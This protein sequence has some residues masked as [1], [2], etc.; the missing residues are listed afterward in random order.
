MSNEIQKDDVTLPG[1]FRNLII[2]GTGVI[3]EIKAIESRKDGSV[4]LTV[5]YSKEEDPEEADFE[6]IQPKQIEN[7]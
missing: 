1:G 3:H 5:T 7:E 6:V 2:H 4:T